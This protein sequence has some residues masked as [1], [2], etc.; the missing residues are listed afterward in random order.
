MASACKSCGAAVV[1]VRTASGKL[2]PIDGEPH[3]DGNLELVGAGLTG[4]VYL[5]ANQ[6]A[7][8][9]TG[10]RYLSHFVTCPNAANHRKPR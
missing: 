10:P 2:M 8:P 9:P 1:W 3:V 6:R 5:S 4:V 7:M